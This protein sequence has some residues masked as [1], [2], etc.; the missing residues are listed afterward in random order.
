MRIVSEDIYFFEGDSMLL[1][2]LKIVE[3]SAGGRD[4]HNHVF[5]PVTFE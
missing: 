3:E 4:R 5:A 2:L 1:R